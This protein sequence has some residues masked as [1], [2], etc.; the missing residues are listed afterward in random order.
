LFFWFDLFH[1]FIA[2][3]HPLVKANYLASPPLVVAYAL[4]GRMD[5]DFDTEPIGKDQQGRQVIFIFFERLILYLKTLNFCHL[6]C[7]TIFSSV[8]F[9][10]QC[11][12]ETFGRRIM[13]FKISLVN[14][15][16]KRCLLPFTVVWRYNKTPNSTVPSNLFELI[17]CDLKKNKKEH[18]RQAKHT[19]WFYEMTNSFV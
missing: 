9:L 7:S 15:C 12:C 5:I 11:T 14:T 2:R 4:A 8:L 19:Q 1:F 13:K 16:W 17:D 18:R 10:D 3:I 6:W